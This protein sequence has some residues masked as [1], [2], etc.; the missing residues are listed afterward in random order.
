MKMTTDQKLLFDNLTKLQQLAALERLKDPLAK[1]GDIY[2]RA[3]KKNNI[4]EHN[5]RVYGYNVLNHKDVIKFLDTFNVEASDEAIMTR[6]EMLLRLTKIAQHSATDV[7]Q[8]IHNEQQMIDAETGEIFEGQSA[9]AIK[10]NADMSLVNEITKG[11]DGIKVK[12]YSAVEA[13]K[14]LAQLQGFNAPTKT[15]I[16]GAEG[17]PIQTK[18]LTDEEFKKSLASLGIID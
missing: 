4:S 15:E 12:T 7:V 18:E 10:R 6:E 17:G 8:V 5:A 16:T 1:N 14:Q 13:M 2:K 11:K 9:F 3:S